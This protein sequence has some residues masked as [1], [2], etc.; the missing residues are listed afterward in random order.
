MCNK[1]PKVSVCMVSY[2]HEKFVGEAIESVLCQSYGNFEFLI[3]EHASTDSS[4]KIIKKFN[5]KRIKLTIYDKNYH[6]TYAANKIVNTACG[7]YFSFICSDDSWGKYKLEEQ[8]KF[9]NNNDEY[10]LVFSRVNVV[11]V[12]SEKYGYFTP[13]DYYFNTQQNRSRFEW[14]RL[15]F[16]FQFNPFC[17][18]SVMMRA[19]IWKKYGPFDIRSRNMQ[20][21]LLWTKI[22]MDKNIYILDKKLTNMRYFEDQTNV[23]GNTINHM[24]IVCNEALLSHE[25]MFS[26]IDTVEKFKLIFPDSVQ[27]Y[28]ML[29]EDDIKFYLARI[30][31]FAHRWDLKSY[32]MNM[33]YRLLG[34][35]EVFERIKE[36]YGFTH[37][38]LYRI[39]ESVDVYNYQFVM[40]F[41][42][43]LSRKINDKIHKIISMA[44]SKFPIYHMIWIYRKLK[45]LYEKYLKLNSI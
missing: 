32:S 42:K 21:F 20:D 2:N 26:S 25:N 7:E 12:N 3:L 22:L 16:D 43:I 28:D 19:D 23:T 45:F 11:N 15:L 8:V 36:R 35:E 39:S 29:Y 40:P 34:D 17:S 33:L 37:L 41:K 5:D 1:N 38:D 24:L 30:G 18:S 4:L 9:L 6:S 31:V 10:G 44:V 13:Y 14:I 27:Q